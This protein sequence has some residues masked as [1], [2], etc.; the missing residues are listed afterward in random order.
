MSDPDPAT[1]ASARPVAVVTGAGSG[2]G[3]AVSRRLAAAGYDLMMVGRR[4][5][6]LWDA[7]ALMPAPCRVEVFAADVGDPASARALVDAA[8][9]RFS[10]LDAL[11]NN[12]GFAPMLPIAQAREAD[13]RAIFD[14]NV[15]GPANAIAQAWPIFA[16]Q[17]RG[18]IVNVS[19]YATVDPFPGLGVYSAAKAGLNLL[20]KACVNEGSSLGIRAFSVAPGAVETP[21]LR[22]IF[23]A[24]VLPKERTLDPDQVARVIEDCVLGRRDAENGR[25]ILVPSPR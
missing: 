23:D 7:A 4:E 19:S 15:I 6:L 5:S 14:V 12:A 21:M 16:R 24:Q 3:L 13:I 2:I 25:T 1:P 18:V 11:I 10:R 17:K 8:V 22:S 20:A 9:R